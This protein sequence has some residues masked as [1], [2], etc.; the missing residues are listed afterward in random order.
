[1]NNTNI[2]QFTEPS[3]WIA[4]AERVNNYLTGAP[5]GILTIV[6]CIVAGW[7]LKSWRRFPNEAI[8]LSVVMVGVVWFMLMA[9][10]K[11]NETALRIWLGRNA[12]IG[13]GLGLFAWG[14]HYFVLSRF[15]DSLPL[16][17]K[18]LS[19]AKAEQPP[20]DPPATNPLDRQPNKP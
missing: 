18:L 11:S 13:S 2:V 9:P 12:A 17:G 16:L 20:A 14:V 19:K 8:P 5:A 7:V 3:Q 6:I 15:E 10:A 1:M 4:W